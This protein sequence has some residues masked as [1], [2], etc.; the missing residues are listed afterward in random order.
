[1]R[2]EFDFSKVLEYVGIPLSQERVKK[3]FRN[4]FEPP[5]IAPDFRGNPDQQATVA[6]V[7]V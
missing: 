7:R 1:M 2:E 6:E 3:V 5:T 4:V